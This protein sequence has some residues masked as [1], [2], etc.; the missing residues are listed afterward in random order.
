MNVVMRPVNDRFLT[1]VAFPAFE[2]GAVDASQG[3]E[4]LRSVVSDEQVAFLVDALLESGVQGG[5]FT[6]EAD[7]WL[8]AVY[9]LLF[10][11]WVS[12]EGTWQV[13]TTPV[14]FAG[15]FEEVLQLSLLLEE[16]TYPYE[17]R[18]AAQHFRGEYAAAPLRRPSLCGLV[19]GA[20]DPLPGFA[21]D[22]VLNTLGRGVYRPAEGLAVAEWSYRSHEQ[23]SHMRAL[24]PDQLKALLE[25]ERARLA[26]LPLLEGRA[27]LAHWLE[28]A[29]LPP[30]GVA[31]SGLGSQAG[32]WAR[33][34]GNLVGLIRNA[35]DSGRGLSLVMT[36]EGRQMADGLEY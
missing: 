5:F 11:E 6:L 29:P 27:L 7:R 34:I 19:C 17:H 21:P 31:F 26:P 22:Q 12:Q 23:I 8:E 1:E 10:S 16:P 2:R 35:A 30:L 4:A 13:Q 33:E 15:G 20:W 25:R 3:L 14:G 9:R 28:G 36:G 24:L 18:E 32:E